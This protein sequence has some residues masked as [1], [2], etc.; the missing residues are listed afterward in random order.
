MVALRKKIDGQNDVGINV[1]QGIKRNRKM[2]Q[3]NKSNRDCIKKYICYDYYY[4]Y[5]MGANIAH[6]HHTFNHTRPPYSITTTTTIT[7]LRIT[8]NHHI[9]MIRNQIHELF[10]LSNSSRCRVRIYAL[11]HRFHSA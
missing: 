5:Y 10:M 2:T 6:I 11:V 8:L 3:P 7:A 4:Y 1:I 9:R